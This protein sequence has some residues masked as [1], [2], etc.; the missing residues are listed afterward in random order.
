MKKFHCCGLFGAPTP[1][2]VVA[3]VAVVVVVVASAGA[4]CWGD[5]GKEICIEEANLG[6]SELA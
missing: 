2:V 5:A 3:V 4:V 6:S 1:P